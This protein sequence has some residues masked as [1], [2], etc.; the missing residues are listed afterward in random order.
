MR[1]PLRILEKLSNQNTC[2]H[3]D[4]FLIRPYRSGITIIES[5]HSSH[6]LYTLAYSSSSEMWPESGA[7]IDARPFCA[8]T[9]AQNVGGGLDPEKSL[10]G[11]LNIVP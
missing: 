6:S 5:S 7:G 9:G 3:L 2:H 8:V 10:A 1:R 11:G 4:V